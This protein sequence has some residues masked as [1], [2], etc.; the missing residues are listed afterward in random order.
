MSTGTAT[1]PGGLTTA[2]GSQDTTLGY[3]G[4]QANLFGNIPGKN[5]GVDVT[6][7]LAT[8]I[9]AVA[10]IVDQDVFKQPGLVEGEDFPA[11]YFQL[12]SGHHRRGSELHPRRAADGQPAD[13]P[14]DHEGR[15]CADRQGDRAVE[16]QRARAHRAGAPACSRPSPTT[17]MRGRRPTRSRRRSRRSRRSQAGGASQVVPGGVLQTDGN[18]NVPFRDAERYPNLAEG[19]A[20]TS[21][22][23]GSDAAEEPRGRDP[24]VRPHGNRGRAA[25]ADRPGLRRRELPRRPG[26]GVR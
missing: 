6:V 20:P 14:G 23:C 19:L 16:H 10:R 8:K 4:G 26:V 11:A 24:Q 3:S 2:Q 1:T 22:P 12:P 25:D 18:T 13:R 21:V 15:P 17:R 5:V 7:N 9:N